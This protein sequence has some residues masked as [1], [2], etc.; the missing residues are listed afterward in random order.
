[1][2]RATKARID[3][4]IFAM[5]GLDPGALVPV[6]ELARKY[7]LDPLVVRRLAQSE[8]LPVGPEEPDRPPAD[9]RRSTSVL[10]LEG[11]RA[12]READSQDEG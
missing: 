4:L 11:L 2:D 6:E 5:R 9:P 7:G 10:D 12:A 8:G 1:M 3:S